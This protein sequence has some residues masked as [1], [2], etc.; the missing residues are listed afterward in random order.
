MREALTEERFY[1][2]MADRFANGDPANDEGGLE[3]GP[4]ETGFDPTNK[5]FY[6]GGD[7]AGIMDKLDYIKGLGTTAIWLTPSFKNRPVQGTGAD[8]SA[9]YHGYWITD[10]TQIDPHFGTNAE[11]TELIDAA[12]DRGMK[13]F[14]D[15]ITNHTADVVDYAEGE[16]AYV[17]KATEPYRDA[18]GVPFDDRDYAG[19]DTFPVL[20]PD[21]SFPYTPV[22]RS[23]EDETIKVPSWLNDKIYYHNRGDSTFAGE[24][25]TY[26]DFVG[27]D[28]LFTEHPDV[29]DGMID[30]YQA[31]ADFG[32]DG[33]R[34]DTVKHVNTEF[35]QE[36]GP[37]VLEHARDAG[38]EDFFMFGEVFDGSPAFMSQYTTNGQLQATLDFGFQGNGVGF[39]Q[40]RP[41]MQLRDLFAGDDYYTDT[42]SNAY[43]LPTFLG[44]HDIGRVGMMLTA[45]SD[46]EELLAARRARAPA[47]VR[48]P[49]PTSRL[50]R[51]RAGL[52]RRR[53][54]QGRPPGHV[55]QPGRVVQRRRDHRRR[56]REHGSVRDGRAAVRGDPE[57]AKLRKRHD[58]LADGAQVHRYSSSRPGVFAFSRIDADDLVEYVVV[59]NNALEAKTATFQTYSERLGFRP[60]LGTDTKIRSNREGRVSVS[61]PPLTVQVFKASRAVD[62]HDAA[63]VLAVRDVGVD[64]VLT[65]GLRSVP[66]SLRRRA[67]SAR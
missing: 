10:F 22:F 62:E 14:F 59:A 24:S 27:L 21:V 26:G 49:R 1:F 50:L 58:A 44:N 25:S 15:I 2:V 18:A 32:I 4:L 54:R 45:D 63:P 29:V 61:V 35:W 46:D 47:D 52:H 56:V 31:W 39:A 40:G 7:L 66:S 53:W 60:L 43:Q 51:R 34:I 38:N 11:M 19:G 36:F 37:A 57:I 33:F 67:D 65:D 64:H 48:Q 16:Y 8:A 6:H 17:D 42:D 20:D 55:R 12:H 5:G 41:T 28:D 3:G 30:I 23:P 9:G 13:V